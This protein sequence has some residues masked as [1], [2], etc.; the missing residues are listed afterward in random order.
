MDDV[1]AAVMT[2][3]KELQAHPGWL[4]FLLRRP[5]RPLAYPNS[6]P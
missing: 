6:I 5:L 2:C 4:S 3:S 1:H